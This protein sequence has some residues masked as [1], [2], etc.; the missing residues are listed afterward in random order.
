[1][2][3]LKFTTHF[4]DIISQGQMLTHSLGGYAGENLCLKLQTIC[5][6]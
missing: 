1:M 3:A 5:I 6:V 4:R 2:D